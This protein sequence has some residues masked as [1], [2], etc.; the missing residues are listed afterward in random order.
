MF[1]LHHTFSCQNFS[2]KEKEGRGEKSLHKFNVASIT[3]ANK[4]QILFQVLI[5]T[6]ICTLLQA[7]II[8]YFSDM[9]LHNL[10]KKKK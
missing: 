7:L 3:Y 9:K 2:L 4:I 10:Y 5:T 1:K 6:Q 8:H